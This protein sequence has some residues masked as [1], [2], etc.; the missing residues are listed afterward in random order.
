MIRREQLPKFLACIASELA[1]SI[2]KEVQTDYAR[3]TIDSLNLVLSRLIAETGPGQ[4]LA[5]AKQP[6]WSQ[7]ADEFPSGYLGKLPPLSTET[8]SRLE[9]LDQLATHMQATLAGP[10][11]DQLVTALRA[12]DA[13]ARSWFTRTASELNELLQGLQDNVTQPKPRQGAATVADDPEELR[14]RLGAYLADR[15]PSLPADCVTELRIATGGQIKRTALFRLVKNDVL[16]ERLVLRQDMPFNFTGTVV[17]DEF[18]ILKRV[19]GLGVLAP[20]PLL[21]EPDPNKLAVGGG[22]QFMIMS[23]VEEAVG[24]GVYF[25]EERA[26]LGHTMGPEF[27]YE[28]AGALARLHAATRVTDRGAGEQAQ[29]QRDAALAEWRETWSRFDKPPFSLAADL[30]AAW[31][32]AHPLDTNRPRTLT[33]GDVGAHNLL[34]REGHLAGVLDWELARDGDPSEDLAQAKMMLLP[35]IMPWERFADA[36][37][38]QGGPPEACDSH[39]VAYYSIWTYLKHGAINTRLWNY[40]ND[41]SRDDAPAAS[42]AGHFI[43]RISLYQARALADAA[44]IG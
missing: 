42:I 3:K 6:A 9:S 13:T 43:E 39:A 44:R 19:S 28:V 8:G 4:Q 18:E 24:A 33:H 37:I 25:P 31:M 26:V 5:T 30:G 38:A 41:G 23:E 12:G 20:T 21:L 10:G 17:T 32:L 36:Y 14:R 16:A 29:R 27:G 22:L 40:F 2:R 15:F 11:L 35:D 7:L 1:G 34:S